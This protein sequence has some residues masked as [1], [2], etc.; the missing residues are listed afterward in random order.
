[1]TDPVIIKGNPTDEEVA[2]VVAALAT[3][4]SA[5]PAPAARRPTGW[6]AYWRSLR[7]PPH[8]SPDAWRTSLRGF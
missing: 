3:L 5:T 1:M 6:S 7:T 4:P 2:A 8:P